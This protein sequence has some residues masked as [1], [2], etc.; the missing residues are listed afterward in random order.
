MV[1]LDHRIYGQNH[2]PKV[3]IAH[4]LFGM[5][6]NW[7]TIAKLLADQYQVHL[8]SMRNH[9]NSPHHPTHD[10]PAMSE[11][12][13]GYLDTKKLEKVHLVGHSMGGKTAMSFAL[14]YAHRLLSLTV[15]DIAPKGYPSHHQHIFEAAFEVANTQ[16]QNRK[17]IETLLRQRIDF[18][19][20][21]QF[22]LKNL[23]RDPNN[24]LVWK[25]NLPSLFSNIDNI[26]DAPEMGKAVDTPSLFIRGSR[27]SYI[28]DSDKPIIEAQFQNANIET[29]TDAGHW[30][31]A[32]KPKE[33]LALLLDFF[34]SISNKG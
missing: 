23:K 18:E 14:T 34:D 16:T 12:I 10:Y 20:E 30:I 31:H 6:D 26:M 28:L 13:L 22:L 33:L 11:D 29:V 24:Y 3:V 17:E 32:E 25:F 8:L 9:G 5:L 7:Q 15:I 4:G 1:A 21:V 27:S 2:L 19:P